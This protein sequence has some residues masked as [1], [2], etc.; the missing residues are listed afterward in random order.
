MYVCCMYVCMYVYVY[1]YITNIPASKARNNTRSWAKD[2]NR[3][4]QF[5]EL[6]MRQCQWLQ[7][8]QQRPIIHHLHVQ[9]AHQRTHKKQHR[10]QIQEVEAQDSKEQL[11]KMYHGIRNA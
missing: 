8:S 1:I 10:Q 5:G 6:N 2:Q 3:R 4:D 7:K 9:T 11:L